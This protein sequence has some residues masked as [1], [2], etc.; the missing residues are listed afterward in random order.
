MPLVGAPSIRIHASTVLPLTLMLAGFSLLKS[1][2]CAQRMTL[3]AASQGVPARTLSDPFPPGVWFHVIEACTADMSSGPQPN[4]KELVSIASP[5][6]VQAVG[7][8]LRP[9]LHRP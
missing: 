9:L 1:G 3:G 6:K 5:S 8:Q 4:G 7:W 2:S